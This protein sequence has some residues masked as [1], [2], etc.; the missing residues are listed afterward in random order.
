MGRNT[1][2]L[3][4]IFALFVLVHVIIIIVVRILVFLFI[5]LL[6]LILCF[7]GLFLLLLLCFFK[8]AQCFP[9]LQEGVGL[10]LVVRDDDVVED[11]ATLHLPQVKSN[12]AEVVILVHGVIILVLWIRYLL[13]FPMALVRWVRDPLCGPLA[14]EGWVVLHWSF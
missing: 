5:S 13:G 9:L 1:S 7:L 12:E 3:F 2:H 6:G 14:L 8:L 4:G 10:S 11:C